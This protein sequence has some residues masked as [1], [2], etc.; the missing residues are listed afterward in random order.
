MN[1]TLKECDSYIAQLLQ[2]IDEDEYLKTHLNVIITSD[3]GMHDVDKSRRIILEQLIDESL[4]SA[5]GGRSFAN[6]FVNKC[7]KL[8]THRVA[9]AKLAEQIIL[10]TFDWFLASDIDRLY[11]NLSVLTNYEV[12]KKSQIPDE[13]HYRLNVRIGGK[14]CHVL[15]IINQPTMVSLLDI[16]IVGRVGYEIVLPGDNPAYE[17]MGD[18]GYDN[19]VE[20]MH[21]IFYA[22]G[23]AFRQ[24]NLA[25]P[26]RNVDLYPL[27]SHIL[28]LGERQTNGS[29]DNVKHVL[30]DFSSDGFFSAIWQVIIDLF[31]QGFVGKRIEE[32]SHWIS[33]SFRS[34]SHRL[35]HSHPAHRCHLQCRSLPSV[36]AAALRGKWSDTRALSSLE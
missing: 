25:K 36:P 2:T 32:H 13:Y 20:S 1:Q 28:G 30:V 17:M 7:K 3:H 6:I 5:Y 26:F 8:R 9:L 18:H 35:S 10:V 19:R 4:F 27:M 11:A 22:F 14:C 24:I 16:L 15:S 21:P 34:S 29:L 31:S 33:F 12:Y 23:P